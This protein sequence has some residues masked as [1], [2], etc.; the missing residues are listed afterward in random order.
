MTRQDRQFSAV[1]ATPNGA[2]WVVA[3]LLAAVLLLAEA[4]EI[5]NALAGPCLSYA[6]VT[7]SAAQIA[8]HEYMGDE[9]P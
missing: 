9:Q 6:G 7:V 8:T 2:L 5:V 4:V 3:A 1:H